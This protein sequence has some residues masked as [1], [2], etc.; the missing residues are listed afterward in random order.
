MPP[1]VLCTLLLWYGVG[2]RFW[3]MKDS[4]VIGVRDLLK[5]YQE[6]S[7]KSA[8]NIVA[9]AIQLPQRKGHKKSHKQRD[10]Q[11]RCGLVRAMEAEHGGHAQQ[12]AVLP[13][14]EESP[15]AERGQEGPDQHRGFLADV[16]GV[17]QQ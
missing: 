8:K 13:R 4:K 10:G 2:Y 12:P 7:D 11:E 6:H 15:D 14:F 16:A 3:V 9:R 5:Y 17:I 1:L